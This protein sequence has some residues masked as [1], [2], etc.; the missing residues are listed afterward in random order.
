LDTDCSM[1]RSSSANIDA[2]SN[3]VPDLVHRQAA[4]NPGAL[5]LHA[6]SEDVTYKELELRSNQTA[7]YLRNMGVS[8]GAV[9]GVC[10]E[11]SVDFAVSALG[12]LKAGCAYLPLETTAPTIRLKAMLRGARVSA[13]ITNSSISPTLHGIEAKIIAIDSSRSE[14]ALCSSEAAAVRIVPEQLAYVIYTSGSTGSPKAVAVQHGNLMNLC[15][16]HNRAFGISAADRATQLSSLSF[17]AAVWEIWPYLIA[18]GSVHFVDRDLRNQPQQLRDWLVSKEITVSFVP[19]PLAEQMLKLSWPKE[20]SFRFMLTGADTLHNYAPAGLP[21]T[22]VNNYGPTEC[23]VV[24][25]SASIPADDSS[26]GLPPIGR[27]IDNVEIY[28]LD[29]NMKRIPAGTLGEIYVAGAGVA[30]GYL[31][32]AALTAERFVANPFQPGTRLYRTGDM[33]SYRADGQISFHGRVDDQVK[34]NGYRIELNEVASLLARHPAIR[35]SI[36]AARENEKGEKQLVA[37]VVS[38]S[39]YPTVSELREHLS[40]EL[41]EYMIPSTF[42]GLDALPLG[43]SG[44]VNRSALPSPTDHNVLRDTVFEGPRTPTEQRV[45][46]VV[47]SL[48]G[49]QQ[50]G[51]N[52]NFFYLGGNSLFGTQVIARLRDAFNVEVSLL[53]LFDHPTVAELAAEVER[54]LMAKLD[55]MTDEEAERLLALNSE[56]T[57]A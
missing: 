44:K 55:A 4:L 56:Q 11:R 39:G 32:D 5:A 36:I 42:V 34:I 51:V 33:G 35:E 13:V 6:G 10:L 27:P 17:D 21:F 29:A 19:T 52:D 48:L 1:P 16:W 24:A 40:K 15:E 46:A 31:N 28:I 23:T 20:T 30:R 38:Q 43:T 49:L 25:T 26:H 8:E 37:Y 9:I 45:A 7:T 3:C 50:V 57:S 47:A 12:I 54:L 22:L 53:K 14:I 18:G 41:P 2:V